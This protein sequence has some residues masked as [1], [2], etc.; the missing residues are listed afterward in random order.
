MKEE[1]RIKFI[2]KNVFK[3]DESN[4]RATEFNKYYEK[5]INL[6]EISR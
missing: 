6:A 1:K 5:Y 2:V 4:D 3:T